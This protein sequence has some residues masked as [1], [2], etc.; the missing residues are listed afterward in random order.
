MPTRQALLSTN[1]VLWGN[2]TLPVGTA[3]TLDC[4][5]GVTSAGVVA[6][7][8]YL[9]MV[10][11]YAAAVTFNASLTVGAEMATTQI[12]IVDPAVADPFDLRGARINMAIEDGL[13]NLY[14][15]QFNRAARF[16]TNLTSWRNV[17][18]DDDTTNAMTALAVQ[19][20]QNHGHSVTDPATDIYQPVVQRA[21]NWLFDSMVQ[22]D[23]NPCAEPGGNPCIGVPAPV[24]IGLSSAQA[25]LAGYATGLFAAAVASAAQADPGR[26]VAAGLGSNNGGFVAGKAYSEILQRVTNALVWGQSDAG[27]GRGGWYYSLEAGT[28]SDGSTMGW[29]LLG[30]IDAGAAGATVP[31]F[32]K[33]EFDMVLN[34]P[35][36]QLNN[37]SGTLD[38]QVNGNENITGNMSKSG[39][40]LQGLHFLGVAA[41]DSRV[42]DV[43]GYL[44]RNWNAQVDG[45]L[46]FGCGGVPGNNKGCGYAM[47]NTFKG[48]RAYGIPTL[49]G[50]TRP[51]GPGTIPAGDWYADYV[52]NLLANQKLPADP[53][54]G[55]WQDVAPGNMAFSCCSGNEPTGITSL[56]LLILSPVAFVLPDPGLF[57]TVGLSPETATNP[58]GTDHTVT[59]RA[60]S[61]AKQPV[62]G[63][64][65]DFRVLT[66]PNAGKTGSDV[67]DAAGE[68]HFTYHDDGG[69]G[70]DRIQAFI[71]TALSSNIVE[72]HWVE[73]VLRCD[74]DADQDVDLDDLRIIRAAT[75]TD[76]SG[77]TDPR[78]GNGDGRINAADVR[79]CT[80][81]CTRAGCATEPVILGSGP[82]GGQ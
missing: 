67:T 10:C 65:I 22:R 8:S 75:R 29:A 3:Y 41:G 42:T 49:P 53:T 2:T 39:I 5:N 72:K 48:L 78:D 7:R 46:D 37:P 59:A 17:N 25:G 68:A 30:L 50:V 56:A 35:G 18:N 4:G 9:S 21:L 33:T 44:S 51:A 45:G 16:D 52:D 60:L 38:Y 40:G 34:V 12:G 6:D 61:S 55:D 28:L 79:Y 31:A 54:R 69:A 32:A 77:P 74:A 27:T 23:M 62:P 73:D 57:S 24:N 70:T 76:A 20:M 47:F 11:N 15:T 19:A 36:Q 14:Y 71:G 63:V 64:T 1:V 66:G 58:V 43:V 26:L 82:N 13:R 81:R 80:V